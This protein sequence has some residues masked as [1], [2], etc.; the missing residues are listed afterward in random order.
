VFPFN[1]RIPDWKLMGYYSGLRVLELM[2][3]N[4]NYS[5]AAGYP[6]EDN[7]TY[8]DKYK[9]RRPSLEVPLKDCTYIMCRMSIRNRNTYVPQGSILVS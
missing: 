5:I 1:F 7:P 8:V 6:L 9:N 3:T 4:K 2:T